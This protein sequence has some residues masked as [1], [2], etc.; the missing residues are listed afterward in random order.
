MS[1]LGLN[2]DPDNEPNKIIQR[3][4]VNFSRHD[5]MKSDFLVFNYVIVKL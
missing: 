5:I 1:D 2:I 3:E 4:N